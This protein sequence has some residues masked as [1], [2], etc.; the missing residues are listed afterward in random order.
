[1]DAKDQAVGN[2]LFAQPCEFLRG[3]QHAGDM[4]SYNLPEVAFWG[5]SNVG[6]SSLLNA[7]TNRLKLAKTSNTPGR[8]QQLN[9]FRLA[10]KLIL[11]DMPG[12]GFAKAPRSTVEAWQNL[13]NDYI[14]SRI[15]LKRI[16]VL[17]DARHGL[18]D[19][20][21]EVMRSLDVMG[22]SYQIV[23]TKVDKIKQAQQDA[24]LKKASEQV[25]LH[26]AAYP[27]VLP[28]SSEY[29]WGIEPLRAEISAFVEQDR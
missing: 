25:L 16:Y 28:T 17:V 22:I 11:V 12:Y 27:Y 29:K 15:H 8:T 9:L 26:P 24:V 21:L 4:P 20:D 10:N 3:V 23:L 1:M 7:L 18:K 6:K 13:I 14:Q 5:R 2:W 19:N